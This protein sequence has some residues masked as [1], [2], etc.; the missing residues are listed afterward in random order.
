MEQY[1]DGPKSEVNFGLHE[2]VEFPM[3]QKFIGTFPNSI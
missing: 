1:T 3:Y 2:T